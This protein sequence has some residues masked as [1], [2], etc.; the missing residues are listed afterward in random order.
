LALGCLGL[1]RGQ[2]VV[3][4]ARALACLWL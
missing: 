4:L 2:P 1:A 3:E